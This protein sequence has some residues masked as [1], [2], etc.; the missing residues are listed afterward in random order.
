ML[1]DRIAPQ[2]WLRL[3]LKV[4]NTRRVYLRKYIAHVQRQDNAHSGL[5]RGR[6]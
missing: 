1:Y 4:E 6:L 3:W 5:R 2:Y